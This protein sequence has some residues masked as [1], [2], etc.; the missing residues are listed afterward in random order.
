MDKLYTASQARE[1]LGGMSTSS[2]KRLVDANKIRKVVPPGKTQGQY[3]KEDVDKLAEAM[4]QFVQIY[5]AAEPAQKIEFLQARD[6]NDIQETVQIARQN[7]G[8]NAYGLDRR[9]PW[10]KLSPKGDYVL[11]H[12]GIVVGYLSVQAIKLESIE[13]VFNRKSGAS[14]QLEDMLPIEPGKP[15]DVHVSGLAVKKGISRQQAKYYGMV[16]L[17]KLFDTLIDLG[18]QGIDIRKI[19]AKSSTVPGIKL[20]RDLGFTELGY[21]NNEQ[22]GFVLDLEKSNIPAIRRYREVLKEAELEA[23]AS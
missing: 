4:E 16:L 22:I 17:N 6:E 1:R 5:S 2:F 9:M 10:F 21:I 11:K 7:L 13:H 3:I 8:D 19:W 18:R 14:L 23:R 20:S 15:L 12:E